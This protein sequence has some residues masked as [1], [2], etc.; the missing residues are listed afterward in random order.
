M[1]IATIENAIYAWIFGLLGF[2]TIFAYPN[3]GRPTTSYVL[4]NVITDTQTGT[5]ETE[6]TFLID[7]SIDN[8]YSSLNEITISINVYYA[9]AYQKAIDIKKSLMKVTVTDQI[10]NAGL[11]Y[12]SATAIQKIPELIDKRWEERAQFDLVF[13]VRETTTE[14]IETIQKVELTNEIDGTTITIGD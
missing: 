5:E 7:E 11:G 2:K 14:N 12:V 10:W 13:N 3:A 9:G 4:V 6:S 8:I 1:T